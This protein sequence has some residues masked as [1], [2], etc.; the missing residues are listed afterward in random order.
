M[1]FVRFVFGFLYVRNW[2][3]GEMELSRPRVTLFSSALFLFL[4]AIT[5][6]AILQAPIEY[7]TRP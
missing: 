5:I 4:L 3:T 2:Y 1:D 7:Q 6:V